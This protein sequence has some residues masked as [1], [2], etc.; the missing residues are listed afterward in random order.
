MDLQEASV[1]MKKKSDG[2]Q[3]EKVVAAGEGGGVSVVERE[4]WPAMDY[5]VGRDN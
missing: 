5:V 3:M 4:W 2:E 1:L